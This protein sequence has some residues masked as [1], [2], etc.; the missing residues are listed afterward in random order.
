M[1]TISVYHP[2]NNRT[3]Q[4]TVDIYSGVMDQ[5][6]EIGS[7]YYF[8]ISTTMRKQSDNSAFPVYVIRSLSDVA[9]GFPVATSFTQ[10]INDYVQYFIN[11]QELGQSSSSSSESSSSS[12]FGVTSSSSSESSSSSQSQ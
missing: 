8:R 10:L 7:D 1:A 11:E 4:V 9:P 12:S 2:E 6:S 5:N 3:Y